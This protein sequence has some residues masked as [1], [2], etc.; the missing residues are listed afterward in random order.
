MLTRP[1]E[2]KERRPKSQLSPD[3]LLRRAES[4]L[5]R[6]RGWQ[7]FKE[8]LE[9]A[10]VEMP[11]FQIVLWTFIA[12]VVVMWLISAI[13]AG[14]FAIFGLWVPWGVR[15]YLKR[16]L[17]KR[18]EAF[19]EQLP[20]N[21]QVL[22]SA[23]RSGH[24]LVGALSVVVEESAEPSKSGFRRVIADEQLG[25]PLEDALGVVVYRMDNNDLEQVALVAALQRK[26]G[27][28]AAEVLDR[29][30]ETVRERFELRRL[31][32]TLTAQGRLS[33]WIVSLLPPALMVVISLINPNYLDPLFS[34]GGGRLLL[35]I[36]TFMVILGSLA[37]K[38]IVEIKV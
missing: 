3:E 37:I 38:K 17:R 1:V 33:R 10:E 24:S 21:L 30:T 19:A 7:R 8:E 13:T 32:K 14:I 36:G 25:V 27:S 35:V 6:V 34:T 9:I 28:S 5:E 4:P 11:A 23:L 12:T 22:S 18:R 20:D 2:K 29:V 15:A 16:R 31:V 26:T